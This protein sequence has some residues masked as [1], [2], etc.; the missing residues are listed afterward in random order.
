MDT[1]KS[2]AKAKAAKKGAVK[3][4]PEVIYVM[5]KEIMKNE[6]RQEIID[7]AKHIDGI[8]ERQK[9]LDA[10]II[11]QMKEVDIDINKEITILENL[12]KSAKDNFG[13]VFTKPEGYEQYLH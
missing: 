4:E 2:R 5:R 13:I 10:K 1:N 3:K 9:E 11:K 7:K 12:K 8:I 6:L